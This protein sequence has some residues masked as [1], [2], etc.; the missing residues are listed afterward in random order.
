MLSPDSATLCKVQITKLKSLGT[1]KDARHKEAAG[2]LEACLKA[3]EQQLR[4][5]QEDSRDVQMELNRVKQELDAQRVTDLEL[6]L[7][8]E[9][10][11]ADAAKEVCVDRVLILC[12]G[13]LLF[14]VSCLTLSL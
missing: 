12:L 7:K 5:V 1:S 4:Q 13:C 9:Q 3:T 2:N 6:K 11:N 8:T 14:A 10:L